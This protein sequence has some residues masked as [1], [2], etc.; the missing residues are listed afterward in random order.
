MPFVLNLGK[1]ILKFRTVYAVHVLALSLALAF[2]LYLQAGRPDGLG[3]LAE[4]RQ[5][6]N[7]T[8]ALSM[9]FY[10]SANA[11]IVLLAPFIARFGIHE[12]DSARIKRE[13][14]WLRLAGFNLLFGIIWFAGS[15]RIFVCGAL[16]TFPWRRS[17]PNV[18]GK[19]VRRGGKVGAH[20]IRSSL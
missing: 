14:T 10:I 8:S 13:L 11:V 15:V 6:A 19:S 2:A 17:P 7:F 1:Q 3:E 20:F 4:P 16:E 5:A 9:L 12:V 18:Q